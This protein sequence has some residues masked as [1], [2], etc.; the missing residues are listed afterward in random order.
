MAQRAICG[1]S[2]T[3]DRGTE[4][5]SR[6]QPIGRPKLGASMAVAPVNGLSV[7]H[8]A[9]LQSLVA[10]GA[11]PK[12]GSLQ[13]LWSRREM[14]IGDLARATATKVTTIRFYEQIGVLDTPARR[15]S[16][17]L[18]AKR[19][20]AGFLDRR[21]PVAPRACQ[22]TRA[23]LC[24]SSGNRGAPSGWC[25]GSASPAFCLARRTGRHERERMLR[26]NN[27]RVQGHSDYRSAGRI[28]T[29]LIASTRS[30]F[31]VIPSSS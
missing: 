15:G 9:S 25:G 23:R 29:V 17:E 14:K 31:D 21:N 4:A 22:S 19:A 6:R 10:V 26:P 28:T 3:R 30:I 8:R 12:V 18:R 11:S 5:R 20:K 27:G 13:S 7:N 1:R 24:G 2:H 16:P